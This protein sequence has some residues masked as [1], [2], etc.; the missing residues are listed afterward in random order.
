MYDT[1]C[2]FECVQNGQYFLPISSSQLQFQVQNYQVQQRDILMFEKINHA[3]A[4]PYSV[5]LLM[6]FR[7]TLSHKVVDQCH[8]WSTFGFELNREVVGHATVTQYVQE[9]T[10][11]QQFLNQY[12]NSIQCLNLQRLTAATTEKKYPC[13][14]WK[15]SSTTEYMKLFKYKFWNP[16]HKW[17]LRERGGSLITFTVPTDT[18]GAIIPPVNVTMEHRWNGSQKTFLW[19]TTENLPSLTF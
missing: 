16:I 19:D 4:K 12:T 2:A 13:E 14:N 8:G 9:I 6:P 17:S 1:S 11:I 15:S 18:N 7:P 5:L 10:S 3:K